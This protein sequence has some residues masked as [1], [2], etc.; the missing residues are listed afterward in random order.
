MKNK[1]GVIKFEII[2]AILLLLV[3]SSILLFSILRGKYYWK[4]NAM[5]NN[6]II[7]LNVVSANI[8]SFPNSNIVYLQE[9]IDGGF[10]EKIKNP[11]G[12]GY[13]STSETF[14][15]FSNNRSYVTLKCGNLLIDNVDVSSDKID[16]YKV[17][18]W[19]LN[20][21]NHDLEERT[22]YNCFENRKDVFDSYIDEYYF[23]YRI[24]KKY[25]TSIHSI[26]NISSCEVDS[27]TFYRI[28][29]KIA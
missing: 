17:S 7:F 24:N 10:I 4:I 11:V 28:K 8:S 12:D 6:S 26:D 2:V 5:R 9:A 14:I 16:I 19:S 15:Y 22:L 20:K 29:K 27:K 1:L 25:H 3:I 18:E 13:C 21:G 23:I